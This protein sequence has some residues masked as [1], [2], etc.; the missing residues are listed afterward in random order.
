MPQHKSA[1]K[2]VKI[3]KTR[4]ARNRTIRSR[5]RTEIKVLRTLIKE[6][7]SDQLEAQLKT[8]ISTIDK[9]RTKG[10]IHRNKS[11]RLKSRLTKHANDILAVS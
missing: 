9:T 2:K 7:N 8:T 10:I 4:T 3:D 1:V 5:L 11:A 6:K